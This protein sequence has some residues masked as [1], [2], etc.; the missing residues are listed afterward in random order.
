MLRV[1]KIN[2]GYQGQSVLQNINF[3][4]GKSRTLSI[5]GA[6]GCGKTT[7]LKIIAG[8]E[9]ADT[10]H[11]F[12]DQTDITSVSPQE[13]DI[14]YI[15]QEAYLYPHLSAYDNIAFGL[16]ARGIS[17]QTIAEEVSHML[18]LLGLTG[19]AYKKPHELSGGQKQR[20]NFGRALIIKPKTLL[21][22][23]PFSNLDAG[24]KSEVQELYRSLRKDFEITSIL[25]THDLKEALMLGDQFA[26]IA[27]GTLSVHESRAEFVDDE[28]TG[29]KR[30]I[31]FWSKIK[32]DTYAD[33]K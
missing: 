32:K 12:M 3:E 13:R 8:L 23:E 4:I 25:V 29:V 30:E 22:D 28:A 7:L 15:H 2:K 20:V 17:S 33:K 24:I 19:H 16:R 1:Q 6:S 10:G 26:S 31:E 21:L 9:P 14:V 11:V 27:A 5:L 18:E